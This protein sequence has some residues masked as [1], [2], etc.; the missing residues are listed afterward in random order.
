MGDGVNE[1]SGPVIWWVVNFLMAEAACN[2]TP[3]L[4]ANRACPKV[5]IAS[6]SSL[7]PVSTSR[8]RDY[9]VLSTPQ[10]NSETINT[11]DL[12]NTTA[13][14]TIRA[15]RTSFHVTIAPP[16]SLV[17]PP[18]YWE[19]IITKVRFFTSWKTSLGYIG[20]RNTFNFRIHTIQITQPN[21]R[22]VSYLHAI[23]SPFSNQLP[24]A[25]ISPCPLIKAHTCPN[26]TDLVWRIMM[27]A[28]DGAKKRRLSRGSVE[29]D[30]DPNSAIPKRFEEKF[31]FR[32]R[33]IKEKHVEELLNGESKPRGLD[34]AKEAVFQD[35]RRFLKISGL[36]L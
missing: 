17:P 8:P 15:V 36:C 29:A 31:G 18:S 6:E 28:D 10:Y 32:L 26:T 25:T 21:R 27:A 4:L 3:T 14:I 12:T 34:E 11:T 19:S 24:A 2:R 30:L 9:H 5:V 22:V 7:V 23:A 13:S 1:K 20:A 16:T 33:S 35:I